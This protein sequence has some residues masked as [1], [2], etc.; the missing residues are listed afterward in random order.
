MPKP[1][2][3]R[4]ISHQP[5]MQI[6]H[7]PSMQISHGGAAMQIS[8]DP[9]KIG[10]RHPG[11]RSSAPGPPTPPAFLTCHGKNLVL[12]YTLVYIDSARAVT[13]SALLAASGE[14][15]RGSLAAKT[16]RDRD[17]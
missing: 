16:R 15:A 10:F 2:S 9:N 7:D 3:T 12:R 5:A 13:D 8:Q 14:N 1:R 17:G 6:S 11:G 4:Q